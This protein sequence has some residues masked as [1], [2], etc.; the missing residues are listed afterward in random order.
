[1]AKKQLTKLQTSDLLSELKR[2]QRSLPAL[3]R[4]QAKLASQLQ[5]VEAQI[6]SLEGGA[7]RGAKARAGGRRQR[8]PRAANEQS[9]PEAMMQVMSKSK[10]MGI[11]EIMEA[12]LSNGYKSNSDN[13]RNIVSQ[14]LSKDDRFKKVDRGQYTIA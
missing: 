9:L 4:K 7:P 1:M 8:A 12:V 14:T 11:G 13:F 6:A 10:P 2:R 3:K 5:E